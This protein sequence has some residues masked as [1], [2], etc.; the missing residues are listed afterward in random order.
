VKRFGEVLRGLHLKIPQNLTWLGLNAD[1][2]R[3]ERN[4]AEHEAIFAAVNAGDA[5]RTSQLLLTHARRASD[6]V[7]RA[8]GDG[9]PAQVA[10]Q[11]DRTPVLGN[12]AS[13][14]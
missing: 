2:R 14:T 5:E 10:R 7:V 13:R 6:L 8:L 3:L 12:H 11:A 1:I 4:A 9:T